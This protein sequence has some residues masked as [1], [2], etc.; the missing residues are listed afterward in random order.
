MDTARPRIKKALVRLLNNNDFSKLTT[1]QICREASLS[2]VTFYIWY[3]SKEALLD[4]YFQDMV[5]DG[6]EYYKKHWRT[7]TNDNLGASYHN[8]LDTIFY[9]YGRYIEFME[10]VYDASGHSDVVLYS[11]YHTIVMQKILSLTELHKDQ[12]APPLRTR[13]VVT[14]SL[15]GLSSMIRDGFTSGMSAEEIR[16][17]ANLILDR[18]LCSGLFLREA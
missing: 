8:L 13:E 15:N 9:L 18:I 3:D 1:T 5:D 4:D 17:D 12:I 14:F 6:V 16:A 2:R 10:R 7:I 11:H